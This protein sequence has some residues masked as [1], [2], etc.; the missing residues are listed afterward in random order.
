MP[1][2]ERPDPTSIQLDNDLIDRIRAWRQAQT[3]MP[4]MSMALRWLIKLGLR[5]AAK[6]EEK[7]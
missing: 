5:E 4:S 6:Q 7:A 3:E 1:Q 2:K